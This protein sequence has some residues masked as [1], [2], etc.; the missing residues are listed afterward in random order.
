MRESV[1]LASPWQRFDVPFQRDSININSS[2]PNY[3]CTHSHTHKCTIHAFTPHVPPPTSLLFTLLQ[4]TQRQIRHANCLTSCHPTTAFFTVD[5]THFSSF[6]P[7]PLQTSPS[8]SLLILCLA[9]SPA[10]F[11]PISRLLGNCAPLI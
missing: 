11:L 10:S 4:Y 6:F 5:L 8:L 9:L 2:V 3:C 1:L 7:F